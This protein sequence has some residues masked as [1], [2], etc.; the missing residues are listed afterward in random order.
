MKIKILFTILLGFAFSQSFAGTKIVTSKSF[1]ILR[2]AIVSENHDWDAD[3]H[4]L[5]CKGVGLSRCAW[6]INPVSGIKGSTV[7]DIE[8]QIEQQVSLNNYSGY[9][10]YN[11]FS[12]S[13]TYNSETD[14]LDYEIDE[15]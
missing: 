13:W 4:T 7:N 2:Y 9:D 14:E 1:T 12:F 10:E 6:A 11:G 8:G 3:I 5:T 15:M